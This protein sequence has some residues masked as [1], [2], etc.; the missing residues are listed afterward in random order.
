MK[1]YKLNSF[2]TLLII[3]SIVGLG[4]FLP[5][6]IIELL[7]N[8]TIGEI[9]QDLI[10]N[11]WQAL[12]LWLIGIIVIYLSGLFK[13]EVAV[14]SFD[15]IDTELIKKKVEELKQKSAEPKP[16]EIEIE[17]KTKEK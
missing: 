9:Y 16:E 14:E 17:A 10:I 1:V 11:S 2:K 12:I 8:S 15:N 5:V 6:F 4:M 13:F 7:W 3:L